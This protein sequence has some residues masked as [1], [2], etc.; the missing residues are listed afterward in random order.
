[1]ATVAADLYR[2]W[3]D[4]FHRNCHDKKQRVS[5]IASFRWPISLLICRL[6]R[7][8]LSFSLPN[9]SL[10]SL[11]WN[12]FWEELIAYF[13]LIRHGPHIKSSRCLATIRGLLPSRCLATIAGG[14][15]DTHTD[16]NVI[17][18]VYSTFSKQESRLKIQEV[19]G[20]TNR[21][22]SLIRH[23]PHWKRRVQQFFYCCLY[24]RYSGNVS[25]EP[26]PINDRGIHIQ[27]RRLMSYTVEMGSGAMI[28]V[29][30]FM[31]IGSGHSKVKRKD[32]QTHR[33]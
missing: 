18:W 26:L 5:R 33:Q 11:F 8:F 16:S 21:L 22:L 20:R 3:R 32:T 23:G 27:T 13:P 28:Y 15:T 25:T 4:A 10:L 29:P 31:K 6:H 24:I 17:S 12:K 7:I 1:M 9:F 30:S 14:Y 2:Y 19:L